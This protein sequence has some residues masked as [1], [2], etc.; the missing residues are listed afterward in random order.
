[1][2]KYAAMVSSASAGA[3]TTGERLAERLNTATK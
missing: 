3:V 2:A 1:M